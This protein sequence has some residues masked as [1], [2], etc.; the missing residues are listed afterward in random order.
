MGQ[1]EKSGKGAKAFDASSE[2]DLGA[3]IAS[4]E[5]QMAL[6]SAAVDP[7]NVYALAYGRLAGAARELI[8]LFTERGHTGIPESGEEV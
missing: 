7:T 2:A 4:A 3:V 6:V 8:G 1:S 5:A